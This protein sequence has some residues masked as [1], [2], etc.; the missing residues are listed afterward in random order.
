[1]DKAL[2]IIEEVKINDENGISMGNVAVFQS[3]QCLCYDKNG[4][5]LGQYG[6]GTPAENRKNAIAWCIQDTRTAHTAIKHTEIVVKDPDG[7]VQENIDAKHSDESTQTQ[8]EIEA[9]RRFWILWSACAPNCIPP[10]KRY[11]LTRKQA[12][13]RTHRRAINERKRRADG[14]DTVISVGQ[15]KSV[16]H[17]TP[18]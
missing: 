17:P 3:G 1:M 6:H 8:V 2:R 5:C 9:K 14:A 15:S 7:I 16:K 12:I 10:V 18:Q 11:G 13:A 4:R